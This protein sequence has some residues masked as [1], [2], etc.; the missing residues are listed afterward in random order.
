MATNNFF[1]SGCE[2]SSTHQAT[3]T[4]GDLFSPILESELAFDLLWPIEC[5][6]SGA[7]LVLGLAF[8][9]LAA[10]IFSLEASSDTQDHYAVKKPE[11]A[12]R[13]G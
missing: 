7:V 8:K 11:L 4:G 5:G 3:I 10:S 1:L 6:R 2:H 13:R 12:T 9:S